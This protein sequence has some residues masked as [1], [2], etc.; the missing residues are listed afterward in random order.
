MAGAIKM[1][2][3]E[4]TRLRLTIDLADDRLTA[5]AATLVGCMARTTDNVFQCGRRK[6][7]TVV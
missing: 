3:R 1:S 4:L 5:D 2:D 7:G 6:D